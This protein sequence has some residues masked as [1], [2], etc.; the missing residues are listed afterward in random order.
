[1]SVAAGASAAEGLSFAQA[2]EMAS[3]DSPALAAKAAAVE[4][5]AQAAIPAG[6]LPDPKVLLGLDNIPIDGPDQYS[7]SRDFMTMQRVGLMQEFPSGAKRAARAAVAHGHVAVAEAQSL[8]TR[9]QVVRQTAIA[10]IAR[11]TAEKQLARF[12]AL[13]A[14]NRL[15]ESAVQVRLASGQGAA[16]EAIASRVEAAQIEER[17]DELKAR[18]D[19][20]IAVLRQ[21]LGDTTASMPLSGEAPDWPVERDALLHGLQHHP[22]LALFDAQVKT[23]DAGID[24][25]RAARHPDWSLEVAYQKR[26][27]QFSNLVSL[28]FSVDLP[29]FYGSRQAPQIAARRAERRG[30]DA[31][32]EAELREH[33]Q[34][35]ESDLV[36]YHRLASA[37]QRQRDVLIPLAEEKVKLALAGWRGGKG[38]LM[39]VV[40]ARSERIDATLKLIALEGERREMAANLYYSYP[41][42]AGDTP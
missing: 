20:A 36:E 4:A 27:A 13:V 22:E 42:H 24:E 7:L 37:L 3:R 9:L 23:L 38:S 8:L 16:T 10:W 19:K 12:D 31:D 11:N 6:A 14:E 28:Q 21:W 5:A 17:R 18:R 1:L 15:L 33:T 26:A 39:D 32:R 25:A 35:I 29:V 40:A 2:I 34:M 30:L 41:A